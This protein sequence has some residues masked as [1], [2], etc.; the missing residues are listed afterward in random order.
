MSEL[1]KA[2]YNQVKKSLFCLEF[3]LV[4]GGL[5]LAARGSGMQAKLRVPS[6]LERCWGWG[7][8]QR[9]H[10]GS[11]AIDWPTGVSKHCCSRPPITQHTL[12]SSEMCPS[13]THR[14]IQDSFTP[15]D[16]TKNPLAPLPYLLLPLLS[17]RIGNF[18]P[19]V[20][21]SPRTRGPWCGLNKKQ[22]KKKGCALQAVMFCGDSADWMWHL[23]LHRSDCS[24]ITCACIIYKQGGTAKFNSRGESIVFVF[25]AL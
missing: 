4:P 8:A 11:E 16:P 2:Q 21:L 3:H 10:P 23:K 12:S 25:A 1:G 19:G 17:L 24:V 20:G 13:G 15:L 6:H 18:L 5:I 7:G 14:R 22:N 9:R